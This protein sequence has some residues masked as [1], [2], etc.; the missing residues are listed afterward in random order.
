MSKDDENTSPP[1]EIGR[2]TPKK[3]ARA[4]T[5]LEQ[6]ALR[7]QREDYYSGKN[8]S[9][10][11]QDAAEEVQIEDV[12][13]QEAVKPAGEL[14]SEINSH[15]DVNTINPKVRTFSYF[16][17]LGSLILGLFI[18]ATLLPKVF[19]KE[20]KQIPKIED[21]FEHLQVNKKPIEEIDFSDALGVLHV[22][23]KPYALRLAEAKIYTEESIVE[24]LLF[25]DSKASS[26]IIRLELA[27]KKGS[28]LMSVDTLKEYTLMKPSGETPFVLSKEYVRRLADYNEISELAGKFEVGSLLRAAF[29][30]VRNNAAGGK[31]ISWEL[32]FEARLAD[33]L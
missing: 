13:E 31:E 4:M 16:I 1:G 25:E 5:P 28:K 30:D 10:D 3:V 18:F 32:R 8:V 27:F 15:Q 2:I 26:P 22:G 6:E 20:T 14:E 12:V 29:K 9:G 24:V 7:Q 19:K 23:D 21:P 11:I 33:A 17:L